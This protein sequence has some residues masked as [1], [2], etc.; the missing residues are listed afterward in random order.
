LSSTCLL[1]VDIGTTH[2][3]ASVFR[4]DGTVIAHASRAT[5]TR[6][7]PSGR[8]YYD[9]EEFWNTVA[10]TIAEATHA[11]E[12]AHIAAVGLTSMAET[13]L[14]LHRT[15]GLP[16]SEMLP[17]FDR[18]AHEQ[19]AKIAGESA[20]LERFR[21]VGLHPSFKC[22]LAKVL[23]LRERD[24]SLVGDSI[25]LSVADYCTYRLTGD[26]ATDYSLAARTCAFRIDE[27][28][29]DAPWMRHWSLD[30]ALFPPAL[31]S[32]HPVGAVQPE[33]AKKTG[34]RA[35]APVAIAGHDHLCAAIAVGAHE[36]GVVFDS[37]GTAESL[38]GTL[39]QA[40][41]G[42]AEWR[43][44]L[45]FGRHVVGDRYFWLGGLSA[46]GGSV[47]WL[48][49]QLGDP[50]LSYA[51]LQTLLDTAP[52]DP[53][54]ILYLPYLSGS[55]T[56]WPDARVQAAFIGLRATHTRAHLLKAVLE[57]TAYEIE[58]IRRAAAE[59]AQRP[60]EHVVAVG[61][62]TRMKP[63]MQI[64]AD[65]SGCRYDV[66]ALD[67]AA[68][69][70]AAIVAG[71]GCGIYSD[72]NEARAALARYHTTTFV[73]DHE[74]HHTYTRLYERGYVRVQQPLRHYHDESVDDAR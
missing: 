8:F 5:I 57:G 24:P 60:I 49:A 14:L 2:C 51:Q 38:M 52:P 25:W 20:S 35:G 69:L 22:G 29:W 21:H 53:T 4:D 7:T 54:G 46:S 47:E 9:P 15:T 71:I 65:I 34:L 44:G 33:A 36:P 40:A 48:R 39:P 30:P 32:G 26:M 64:K 3:K 55:G 10:T 70:G 27:R 42:P 41:L 31:P 72:V 56:P 18:A 28:R 17:W 45:S 58:A 43:S 50:P 23:W 19:A 6:Q 11:I 67:E 66:A 61:G 74:R 59:V 37:M 13:G 12:P 73:P 1:G 62:G 68:V 63:W 16:R